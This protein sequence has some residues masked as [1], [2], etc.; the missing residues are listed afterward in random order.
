MLQ[1]TFCKLLL[2]QRYSEVP[3]YF[4]WCCNSFISNLSLSVKSVRAVPSKAIICSSYSTL[5]CD[6]SDACDCFP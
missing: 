5:M 6:A 2:F 1:N 3:F 4:R